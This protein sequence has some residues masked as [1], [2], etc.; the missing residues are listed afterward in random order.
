MPASRTPFKHN[1]RTL[2]DKYLNH[3]YLLPKTLV[4]E[5]THLKLIQNV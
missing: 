2:N 3:Q 1:Q 4:E 5:L